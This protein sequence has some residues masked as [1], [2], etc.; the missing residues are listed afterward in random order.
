M[1]KKITEGKGIRESSI[2]SGFLEISG[3]EMENGKNDQNNVKNTEESNLIYPRPVIIGHEIKN[4]IGKQ[5]TIFVHVCTET[6]AL[7]MITG[8]VLNNRGYQMVW[9]LSRKGFKR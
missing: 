6:V 9:H 2:F 8:F 5:V 4:L 3:V 1:H 7:L